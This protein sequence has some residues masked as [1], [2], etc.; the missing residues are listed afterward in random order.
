L[1]AMPVV[2]SGTVQGID[3]VIGSPLLKLVNGH[4]VYLV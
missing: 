1:N 4:C 3:G 2:I